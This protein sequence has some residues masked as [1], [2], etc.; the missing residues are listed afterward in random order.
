MVLPTWGVD[1]MHSE[2][3]KVI[4]DF[5]RAMDVGSPKGVVQRALQTRR[6]ERLTFPCQI[7]PITLERVGLLP[8]TKSTNAQIAHPSRIDVSTEIVVALMRGTTLRTTPHTTF[9]RANQTFQISGH[10]N[11]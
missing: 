5:S 1:E 6:L 10:S 7:D 4:E 2:L 8:Q 3:T 11:T 9:A